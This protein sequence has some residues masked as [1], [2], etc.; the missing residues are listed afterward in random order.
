MSAELAEALRQLFF[1]LQRVL[2][3][4]QE[5]WMYFLNWLANYV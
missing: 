1:F 3:Q 2:P 4:Y 5:I